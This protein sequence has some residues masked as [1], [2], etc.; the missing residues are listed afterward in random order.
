MCCVDR[1]RWQEKVIG[2]DL[3]FEIKLIKKAVIGR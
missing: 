1:L 3:I 2:W